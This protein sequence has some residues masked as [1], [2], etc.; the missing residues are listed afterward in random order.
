MVHI[1]KLAQ[2]NE[3]LKDRVKGITPSESPEK[4]K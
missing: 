3:E 1:T 2:S 4:L